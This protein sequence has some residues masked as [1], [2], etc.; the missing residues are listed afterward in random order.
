MNIPKQFTLDDQPIDIGEFLVD[1]EEDFTPEDIARIS[2][3]QVGEEIVYG[4]GAFATFTL[5]RVK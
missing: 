5:K 3:L 2:A 4:G 1:N